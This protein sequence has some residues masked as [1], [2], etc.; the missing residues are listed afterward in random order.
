[1]TSEE[2]VAVQELERLKRLKPKTQE[3]IDHES[4]VAKKQK[5]D[6]EGLTDEKIKSMMVI[7]PEDSYIKPLQVKHPIIDWEVFTDGRM[8]GWKIVRHGDIS[9]I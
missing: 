8:K 9:E 2:V 3:Q 4:E 5:S 1:M 7:I 6:E